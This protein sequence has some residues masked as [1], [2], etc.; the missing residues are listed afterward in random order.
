MSPHGHADLARRWS[1]QQDHDP[2]QT[3]VLVENW[4]GQ[5]RVKLLDWPSQSIDLN[6][7]ECL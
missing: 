4:F 3:L 1:F 2:K 5:R 6:T 7:V